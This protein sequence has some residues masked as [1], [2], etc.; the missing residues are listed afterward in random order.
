MV[1][2]SR[3]NSKIPEVMPKEFPIKGIPIK[4]PLILTQGDPILIPRGTIP[5]GTL[6]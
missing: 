4:D 3:S 2:R 6:P 5:Q 1:I